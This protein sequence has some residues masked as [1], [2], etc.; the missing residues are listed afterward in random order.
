MTHPRRHTAPL[1]TTTDD[2]L[3]CRPLDPRQGWRP[4]AGGLLLPPG[5]RRPLPVGFDLFA[6][7]GGFSL[8]LHQAGFHVAAA[9]EQ[10]VWAALTYLTNLARPGVEIHF[11]GGE[12]DEERFLRALRKQWGLKVHKG[13]QPRDLGDEDLDRLAEEL[14]EPSHMTGL[15]GTGWIAHEPAEA[16]GCEHFYLGDVKLLTG[17]RFMA[18]LAL[19]PGE[20]DCVFGGPPC[21][22]FSTAGRRD[23]MDRGTRSS[24]SSRAWCGRRCRAPA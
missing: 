8:G 4:G 2:A 13:P 22:G 3:R 20:L 23:V 9:C 14:G 5:A 21:Q 10:D 1:Q 17:E 24:S 11:L 12:P 6:G 19:A 18:D 15:A 7:A 16:P